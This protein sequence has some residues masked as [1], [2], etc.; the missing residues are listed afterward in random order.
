MDLNVFLE[1]KI[2]LPKITKVLDELGPMGRL[3][4]IRGWER[5]TQ[6]ALFDAARGYLPLTLEHFVPASVGSLTEVIHHGKNSLAAFTHFQKRFC[7]V[8][9]KD[10]K[11]VHVIGYN[12]QD[13]ALWTGPGYYYARQG[14]P[15]DKAEASGEGEVL[16]DYRT[17]P[18]V[19][20]EGWPEILP[21]SARLGR[22]VYGG[23]IDV[24]RGISRHV[25]IGRARKQGKWM[26]AWFVLCRED[27]D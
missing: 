17:V 5:G 4:T 14:A 8:V 18:A 16:I 13:M 21:N 11:D 2:K 24:M 7:R 19:K 23:M 22:F 12:H 26:D 15:E 10:G 20:P 3:E 6:S 1:P 9:S 25:S 27:A